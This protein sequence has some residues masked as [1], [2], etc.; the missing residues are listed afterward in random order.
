[1][2]YFPKALG[3]IWDFSL[4]LKYVEEILDLMNKM[5]TYHVNF[6]DAVEAGKC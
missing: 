2:F 4:G 5:S 3:G 1:M 6:R